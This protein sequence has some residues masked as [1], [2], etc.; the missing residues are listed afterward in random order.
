MRCLWA[1]PYIRLKA[2]GGALR[3]AARSDFP[4]YALYRLH[5]I[6]RIR[7]FTRLPAIAQANLRICRLNGGPASHR[8]RNESVCNSALF[9]LFKFYFFKIIIDVLRTSL[10]MDPLSIL[11][12]ECAFSIK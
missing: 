4:F 7:G 11:S 1:I 8:Y 10:R 2:Y 6:G 5:R 12:I 3:F 9:L